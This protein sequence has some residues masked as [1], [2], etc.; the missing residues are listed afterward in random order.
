MKMKEIKELLTRKEAA[1]Y[2]GI[3]YGTLGMWA[4]MKRHDLPYIKVGKRTQYRK[5]DLDDLIKKK[6]RSGSKC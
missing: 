6:T 4:S 1:D 5:S 2:L 3:T